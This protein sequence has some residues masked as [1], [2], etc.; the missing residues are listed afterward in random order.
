MSCSRC[1]APDHNI[2][3]CPEVD[4]KDL[5]PRQENGGRPREHTYPEVFADLPR[6]PD[7]FHE[8][9]KWCQ[10]ILCDLVRETLQGRGSININ[11]SI[12][13]MVNTMV[14]VGAPEELMD[15]A[16]ALK[17]D[18][19]PDKPKGKGPQTTRVLTGSRPVR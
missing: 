3:K 11:A 5:V 14:K 10:G 9:T 18:K 6:A 15:A 19:V 8:R 4:P 16:D 2:R 13:S 17:K 12:V 7:S 1:N